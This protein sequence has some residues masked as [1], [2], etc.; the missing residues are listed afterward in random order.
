MTKR[1]AQA[2]VALAVA[3]ACWAH[4]AAAQDATGAAGAGAP[5]STPAP[6]VAERA[7]QLLKQMGAYLAAAEQ[8][9]FSAEVTFDHVLP[10]GQT[11]QFAGVEDVSVVRPNRV[12]VDWRSDLGERRFWYDGSNVTLTDPSTPFYAVASAPDNLDA[13]LD[14]IEADLG[15]SPPLGDFLY[16]DPYKA[17]RSGVRYGIDL[18]TSEVSGRE[19]HSLAFVGDQIDW[20]NL[21]RRRPATDA[22]QASHHLPDPARETAVH[23][24]LHRLGLRAPHRRHDLRGRPAA[25]GTEDPVQDRTDCREPAMN[26]GRPAMTIRSRAL[27]RVSTRLGRHPGGGQPGPGRGPGERPIRRRLPG[28]WLSRR[29]LRRLPSR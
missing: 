21:D 17:L 5:A 16:A 13:M 11:L 6:V 19:C 10:T 27:R 25:W 2:A 9:T 24:D 29:R 7:D 22:L 4:F 18:G 23:R 26:K 3:T 12:A 15:F 1:Q 8:F 20:Q 14:G 28:R